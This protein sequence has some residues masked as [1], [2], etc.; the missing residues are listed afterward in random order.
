MGRVRSALKAREFELLEVT[1][2]LREANLVLQQLSSIDGLTGI[3]N[4][5]KFDESLR[6]EWGSAMR[7]SK[8][9]S[10][11]IF[12]IDFFKNYNDTYGHLAR[13]D[14]LKQI[15]KGLSS[16]L[17]RSDDVFARYGG[18]EFAVILPDTGPDGAMIVAKLIHDKVNSLQILHSSSQISEFLTISL[19]VA[20]I[21]PDRIL[22]LR[23]L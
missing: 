16:I 21:T 11:I 7:Y 5:R 23:Y 6:N 4:R 19:G 13:D 12:D 10:L 9:I 2:K 17:K 22:P 8:P 1:Q 15:S 14:C 20:T 3:S 18:E